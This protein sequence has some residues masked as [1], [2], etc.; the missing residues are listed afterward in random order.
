MDTDASHLFFNFASEN[1]QGCQVC[2]TKAAHMAS[3]I[4]KFQHHERHCSNITIILSK[5]LIPYTSLKQ[6]KIYI[7]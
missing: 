3:I 1:V 2:M 7:I 5:I 4:K 6:D